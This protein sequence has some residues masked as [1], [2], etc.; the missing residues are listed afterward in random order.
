MRV[1]D[2]S[3]HWRLSSTGDDTLYDG[4]GADDDDDDADEYDDGDDNDSVDTEYH[5]DSNE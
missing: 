5:N 1:D 4:S 3:A 2:V